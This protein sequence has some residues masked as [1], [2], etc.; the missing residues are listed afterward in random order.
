[1]SR[2]KSKDTTPEMR[3]R[4][5]LH[6]SGFRYRLHVNKLPGVPDIVLPRYNTVVFVNGCFWHRHAD[7]KRCTFPNSNEEYWKKKFDN[8]MERDQRNI[9]ALQGLG[10]NVIIIWECEI[11]DAS[12]IDD[13]KRKIISGQNRL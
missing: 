9:N 8:T 6:R 4:T 3:V 12:V 1:M 5:I 10:W 7:C 13:I 2:I 11:G